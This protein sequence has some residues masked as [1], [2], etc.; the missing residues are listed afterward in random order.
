[1]QKERIF[2]LADKL[3]AMKDKK[4]KLE[5]D[6]KDINAEIEAVD[7]ELSKLMLEAE[8]PNFSRAG[9]T[10]YLKNVLHASPISGQ[11]DALYMALKEH[12]FGDLVVETVNSRTLDSFVKEQIS[13]NK[14]VMPKW[15]D[16]VVST[17]EKASVGVRKG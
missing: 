15:L 4:K 3:K 5:D 8:V 7:K 13:L 1:M 14:D 10:F 12:G 16:E 6:I 2:K 9:N 17:F 11:K